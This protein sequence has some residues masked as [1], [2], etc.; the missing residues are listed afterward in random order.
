METVLVTDSVYSIK[1]SSLKIRVR[2]GL[3]GS[4]TIYPPFGCTIEGNKFV[5]IKA[6]R[7]AA[8][9]KSNNIYKL[10]EGDFTLIQEE[11]TQT[12]SS[13]FG[14]VGAVTPANGDYN[15][16][17]VTEGTNLY[18]TN[19][20][21]QDA[22]GT[23]LQDSTSIA[24]TYSDSDPLIKAEF[25]SND[26]SQFTNDAGYV[27]STA[28]TD[29]TAKTRTL[30]INGSTFDLSSDRSWSVGTVTSVSGTSNRI[31]SSGGNTPILDISASYVGQSSITT[32][33]TVTTGTWNASTIGVSKGGTGLTAVGNAYQFLQTNSAGSALQYVDGVICLGKNSTVPAATVTGTNSETLCAT[34]PLGTPSDGMLDFFAMARCTVFSSGG[35]TL[36]LRIGSIASPSNAQAAAATLLAQT[37]ISTTTTVY[38]PMQR[39]FAIKSGASGS[40][41]GSATTA[42]FTDVSGNNTYTA[43]SVDF[44]TN[45]YLYITIVPAAVGNTLEL[46]SYYCNKM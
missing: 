13:V 5:I 43:N 30:T 41:V 16:D 36:R 39:H 11:V 17:Q 33:G 28:L 10:I 18:F 42:G 31:T 12:V 45:Q 2:A 19:E 38:A 26:I 27:D 29:Y 25:V 34:I 44:S 1:N 35:L 24:L 6:G 4:V 15:T 37:T 22:I 46:I 14:R 32:L 3:S 7:F 40:I 8:F 20:R 23:I 9:S 21:A